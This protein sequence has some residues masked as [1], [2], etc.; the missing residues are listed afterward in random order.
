MAPTL[1]L[2]IARRSAD[3][4]VLHGVEIADPYR[5]LEDDASPEVQDWTCAQDAATRTY[6]LGLPERRYFRRRLGQLLNVGAVGVP[7]QHGR[8]VFLSRHRPG[9]NQPIV[10]LLS[11]GRERTVLD[12]NPL[13]EDGTVALDWWYPSRDGK[14]LAYGLSTAGDEQSTLRVRD[15]ASGCDL[16][17]TIEQA[18]AASLAWLPDGR[19]F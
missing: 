9:Q 17:D 13:S 11:A 18:R 6:L 1:S 4:D 10:R 2:P 8:R 12:P 19:G 7:S 14:L 15:V 3:V 16:P 5:W